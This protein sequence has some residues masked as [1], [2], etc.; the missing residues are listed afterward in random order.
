MFYLYDTAII[1]DMRSI[2]DDE[3]I[4]ICPS[5]RVF[6]VIARLNEDDVK[7]PMISVA[8]TGISLL[9]SQHTMRFTGGISNISENEES[10][11]RIQ[12]IPIQ[13]NYQFDVWTKHRE[14]NDNIIRELIFYYMT[15]PTLEV[16][17]PYGTNLKHT[18]NIFYD[19]TIEDNS[20]ISDQVNHGEYFRQTLSVYTP[21]AYL[22]KSTT[23]KPYI[24][25]G[26]DLYVKDG[27]KYVKD[28]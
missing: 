27:D 8:R 16:K 10:I 25:G 9:D 17:V 28:N 22:W 5:D 21:D 18:F 6:S 1:E 20:D 19:K 7:L 15:H 4:Y 14:E 3:R 26:A 12:V 2:L 11:S 13:I 23:E 24:F